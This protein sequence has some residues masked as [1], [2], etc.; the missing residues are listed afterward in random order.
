MI[1]SRDRCNDSPVEFAPAPHWPIVTGMRF[2][3][4]LALLPLPAAAW[5]FS[6]DPICTLSHENELAAFRITHDAQEGIYR[7]DIRRKNG[8][9]AGSPTFGIDF[10]GDMPMRIGTARHRLS[11]DRQTL[12]VTDR[13]FSN[14]LN[15]LEFNRGARAFT[16]TQSVSLR[17]DGITAPMKAFRACPA[18]PAATS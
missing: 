11:G 18:E 12:S 4:I 14:V 5:E 7:L 10:A 16:R 2:A 6:P 3:L 13:G 15:G 1:A 17:T 9:W 8:A